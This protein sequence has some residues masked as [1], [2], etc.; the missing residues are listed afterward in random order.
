MYFRLVF[1][2]AREGH[3]IKALSFVNAKRYTPA[4]AIMFTV[5]NYFYPV[6]A[7]YIC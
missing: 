2:A 7:W 3:M 4:P 6:L 5:S 1:V